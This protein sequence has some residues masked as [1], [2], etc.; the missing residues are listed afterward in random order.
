MFA[1]THNNAY[2]HTDG[3]FYHAFISMRGCNPVLYKTEKGALNRTKKY[4]LGSV[5]VTRV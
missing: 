1:I 5:K 4:P 3:R 2:L